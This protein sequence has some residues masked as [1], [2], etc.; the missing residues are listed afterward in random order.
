MKMIDLPVMCSYWNLFD[1]KRRTR[2]IEIELAMPA[3]TTIG[4][5]ML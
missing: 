3:T 1:E 5:K 4:R 2:T